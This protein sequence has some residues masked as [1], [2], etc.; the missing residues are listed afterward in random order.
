VKVEKSNKTG[1]RRFTVKDLPPH[2][3]DGN[4][5]WWRYRIVPTFNWLMAWYK[6][7]WATIDDDAIEHLQ[8]IWNTVY[9]KVILYTIEAGDAVTFIVRFF[10]DNITLLRE[11]YQASQRV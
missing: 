7:L 9:G 4:P 8:Q 5:P 10:Q 1:R 3:Q 11:Y 6:D 2:S